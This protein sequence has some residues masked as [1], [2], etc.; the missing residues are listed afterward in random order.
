MFLFASEFLENIVAWRS[1]W[2]AGRL[3]GGKTLLAVAIAKWLID[4]KLAQGAWTNFPCS[5][6]R[7]DSIANC[8][9]ILDESWQFI[10]ARLSRSMYTLY[11][12]WARK[13]GSFW[14]FP[15]IYPPDVRVRSVTVARALE[16]IISPIP[17]W[18][19][20]YTTL[21]TDRKGQPEK[22][23][24]LLLPEPYFGLYDTTWIPTDDAGISAAIRKLVT[25]N[26]IH[27]VGSRRAAESAADEDA[28]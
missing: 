28:A 8:V 14:L 12:A 17:A 13:I 21:A 27:L 20:D 3:G 15:S 6:P 10:D 1:A 24:F 7:A 22:H 19:Y 5:L 23:S 2:I 25:D 16:L 9:F 26:Q 11:G 18:L 4:H